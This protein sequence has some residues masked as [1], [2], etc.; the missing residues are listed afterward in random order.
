MAAAR[1]WLLGW[2]RVSVCKGTRSVLLFESVGMESLEHPNDFFVSAAE[3]WLA[4]GNCGEAAAELDRIAPNLCGH[5]EVL[6]VRWQ[7]AIK[8]GRWHDA[9]AVAETL[10]RLAPSSPFGWIHRSYCLH[11]LKQT[12]EAWESL[13]PTA[14]RFPK[15]WLICY[16]LACYACQLCWL[17]QAKVW[18]T[19]AIMLGGAVQVNRLAAE[20]PDLK[21]L[22][23]RQRS[24]P[25]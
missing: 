7:I 20:D 8:A 25:R 6:E 2:W 23:Q 10:C 21:P 17:E 16:N 19:R 9:L 14:D 13:L 18:L 1:L 5:P 15:E 4:L 24:D 22:V 3:G 11:E 12:Q